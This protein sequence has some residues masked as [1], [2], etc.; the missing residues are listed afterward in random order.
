M[1]TTPCFRVQESLWR[2]FSFYI[3]YRYL[4]KTPMAI[5]AILTIFYSVICYNKN[6]N[7][8]SLQYHTISPIFPS[9][10]TSYQFYTLAT[11]KSVT[12]LLNTSSPS[13]YSV[14]HQLSTYSIIF[15]RFVHLFCSYQILWVWPSYSPLQWWNISFMYSCFYI[16]LPILKLSFIYYI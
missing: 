9:S 7:D 6:M 10:S 14:S 11:W 2:I 13:L 4:R 5:L 12:C 8:L 3:H 16:H 15:P 1:V